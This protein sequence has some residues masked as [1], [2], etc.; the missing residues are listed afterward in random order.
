MYNDT[1]GQTT[2][3]NLTIVNASNITQIM[4]TSLSTSSLITFTYNG[5]DVNSTYIVTVTAIHT[6]Y[7]TLVETKT[8]TFSETGLYIV[9]GLEATGNGIWMAVAAGMIILFVMLSFSKRN[10]KFGLATAAVLM[11][12]FMFFGWFVETPAVGWGM[13][14]LLV[15]IATTY[16]FS[17]GRRFN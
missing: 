17:L 16:V 6:R 4:F 9:Q 1:L 12:M 3:V 8:I 14:T 10:A 15:I 11:A 2:S 7:G 5:V 13:I